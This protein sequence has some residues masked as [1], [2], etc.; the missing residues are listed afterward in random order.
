MNLHA[1]LSSHDAQSLHDLRD[2]LIESWLTGAMPCIVDANSLVGAA[3]ITAAAFA[4][5]A[6]QWNME[7][8]RLR[9]LPHELR[10]LC[11]APLPT[12][13]KWRLR[14]VCSF[15]R[16][17]V[18]NCPSLWADVAIIDDPI[19]LAAILPLSGQL[20]LRVA[21]DVFSNG[22][23]VR[24]SSTLE[25]HAHRLH[26][27][28]IDFAWGND[29]WDLSVP[30][31]AFDYPVPMLHELKLDWSGKFADRPGYEI[32][33]GIFHREI[34]Q[35]LWRLPDTGQTELSLR[36]EDGR[37]AILTD[38][39]HYSNANC[40]ADIRSALSTHTFRDI[41]H[42]ALPLHAETFHD[43]DACPILPRG[44]IDLPR[45]HSLTIH[46]GAEPL[47]PACPCILDRNLSR[48][49][50]VAPLLRR[51]EIQA[52]PEVDASA[53]ALSTAHLAHFVENNLEMENVAALELFLNTAH[54]VKLE[55]GADG[56][57]EMA[58]L[59][60]CVGTVHV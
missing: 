35:G 7:H 22:E 17:T 41:M 16:A 56:D 27:L 20:P 33:S 50:I 53:A 29:S 15:W 21:L 48:G 14:T 2:R 59:R 30:G 10:I 23:L 55:S 34:A 26:A 57:V 3:N 58:R 8:D 40:F 45:L 11:M 36:H 51:L 25:Q 12:V 19:N 1:V 43:D 39:D 6:T 38:D 32:P 54:G 4:T 31:T 47:N 42:L 52:D 9:V 60:A 44:V 49:V 28:H 24:V 13:D 37:E 5:H 46:C 18:V